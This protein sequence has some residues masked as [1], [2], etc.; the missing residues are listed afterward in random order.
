MEN[1]F[2]P[3]GYRGEKGMEVLVSVLCTI[4]NNEKHIA[5]TLNSILSQEVNFKYEIIVHDDAST[6]GTTAIIKEYAKRYPEIVRTKIQEQNV[7]SKGIDIFR[8][9]MWPMIRGKYIAFCEGDDYWTD[10]RKLQKQVELL[11]NNI[12]FS[13]C[14]HNT[15]VF[16]SLTYERRLLNCNETEAGIMSVDR[17]LEWIELPCFHISSAVFRKESI[18]IKSPLYEKVNLFGDWTISLQS[19]MRG[20]VFYF[21]EPLSLY[22]KY[23]K[24]SWTTRNRSKEKEIEVRKQ[25]IALYHEFDKQ[26]SLM[27]HRK[28][29]TC[30]IKQQM[31]IESL[32]GRGMRILLPKYWNELRA[33]KIEEIVS[34]IYD[35]RI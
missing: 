21:P 28:V 26:T 6:D 34:M 10:T 13:V 35:C 16:N 4:Y 25:A 22:R 9:I 24:N 17:L 29:K 19:A 33:K 27:Y 14:V 32:E 5:Q 8:E 11:E 23:V 15:V 12:D 3:I 31:E 30:I 7:Y 2:N 18:D 1:K 20:K